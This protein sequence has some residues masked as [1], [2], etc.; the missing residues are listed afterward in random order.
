MNKNKT[1]TKEKEEQETKTNMNA[2]HK[3]EKIMNEK[4]NEQDTT[5]SNTN[6]MNNK[7]K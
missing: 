4:H 1:L 2:N 5:M 6:T 7:T 3:H